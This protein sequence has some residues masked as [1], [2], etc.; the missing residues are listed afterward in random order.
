MRKRILSAITVFLMLYLLIPGTA[1]LFA[2]A[3]AQGGEVFSSL[4][5]VGSAF[6]YQ[7]QLM[8]GGSPANGNFD[9]RF[10]LFDAETNGTQIGSAIAKNGVPV[11]GGVFTVS[12][13]FGGGAFDGNARWLE[14]GVR[15]GG[16]S[17]GFTTLSPRQALT[18]APYALFS[19]SAPWSGLTGVPPGFADGVDND[20]TYTAGNGLVITGTQLSADF[21][22][23]GSASTVAHSDHDHWGQQWSGTFGRGLTLSGGDTGI[24]TTASLFGVT[25]QSTGSNGKGVFGLALNG[26]GFNVGVSGLSKSTN[27]TGVSGVA[28]A[29]SGLT[30]GVYGQSKST[31]GYGVFGHATAASGNTEG[32]LGRSDSTSGVGVSGFAAATTGTN[33]GVIGHS[34]STS[35]Y[36]VYGIA[37]ADSGTTYGV[38]GRSNSVNGYGVLGEAT[39]ASGTN[40]GVFGSAASPAGYAGYFVGKVHVLGTLSKLA[41]SFRIDHPLDPANKYLNH[42]FV[43]SP[44]MK[45]IYDGVTQLDAA[46]EAWVQLPDWFEAL[47]RD[48]RYQL[49]P[50]G[51]AM[52]N[53]YIAQEIANNRFKIAGGVPGMKVSWQATGIRHD[54]YAVQNPIPVEEDKPADE[55]GTYLYPTGYGQPP[56]MGVDYQRNADLHAEM[57]DLPDESANPQE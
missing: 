37:S 35:G 36:G 24:F 56:E 16:S 7:G 4:A 28:E 5:T 38:H 23:T 15:P 40:Y 20:T 19:L 3:L 50:I 21:A 52:P 6:T 2:V 43:E 26:S 12:L 9:F 51:A 57:P 34:P 8:D 46:G 14:I 44:D 41:G 10:S 17:G 54:P 30:Y 25:G 11:T 22:G 42:S 45:N 13:D 48:F 27:G 53:L 55:R 39:A 33:Y 47:N 49:T 31:R 1:D 18:A 29:A 32:V